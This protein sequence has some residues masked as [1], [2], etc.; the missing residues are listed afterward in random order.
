MKYIN[1]KFQK[2]KF[3][4]MIKLEN[5]EIENIQN[6]KHQQN[7]NCHLCKFKDRKISQI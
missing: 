1:N 2:Y 3:K 4:R 7:Q 5:K 6:K